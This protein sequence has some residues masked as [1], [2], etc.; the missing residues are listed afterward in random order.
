VERGSSSPSPPLEERV[1]ERRPVIIFESA[2]RGNFTAGCRTNISGALTESD[3]LLFAS[4]SSSGRDPN[5]AAANEHRDAC[6]EQS[7]TAPAL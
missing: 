3:D 4:L 7:M 6:T 2:V 1:G 5:G